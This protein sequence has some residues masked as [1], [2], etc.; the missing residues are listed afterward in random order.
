MGK[1][2]HICILKQIWYF[3]HFKIFQD[4]FEILNSV[5]K[6]RLYDEVLHFNILL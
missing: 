4:F 1:I 2:R 6:K 5:E 3:S